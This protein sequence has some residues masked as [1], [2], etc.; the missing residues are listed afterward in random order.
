M[1]YIIGGIVGFMIGGVFGIFTAAL[2]AASGRAS[3]MEEEMLYNCE[4]E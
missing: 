1:E 4:T 2:C 3:R